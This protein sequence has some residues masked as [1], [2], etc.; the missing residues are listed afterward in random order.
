MTC[1]ILQFPFNNILFFPQHVEHTQWTHW[2]PYRPQS[3]CFDSTYIHVNPGDIFK[4]VRNYSL[5]H[6]PM[7]DRGVLSLIGGLYSH[8]SLTPSAGQ[9][10]S[11]IHLPCHWQTR[12]VMLWRENSGPSY[13]PLSVPG[14]CVCLTALSG[15]HRSACIYCKVWLTDLSISGHCTFW[16]WTVL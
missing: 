6:R 5:P 2:S 10:G 12:E 15:P 11:A 4:P 1:W 14:V 7:D 13:E 9:P 3:Q 16:V 8:L